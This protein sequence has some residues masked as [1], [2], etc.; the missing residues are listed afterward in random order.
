[1]YETQHLTEPIQSK[2]TKSINTFLQHPLFNKPRLPLPILQE[3]AFHQYSDSILWVPML[4]LMLSKVR[5]PRLKRALQENIS[6]ETGL[7]G[8]SHIELA[9]KMMRS[10]GLTNLDKFPISTYSNS[11][12]MWLSNDFD[13]FSEPEI[14]GWLLVAETLVPLMFKKMLQHFVLA[15]GCDTA[16]FSEHVAVDGDEHS[17]WMLEAATEIAELGGSVAVSQIMAG[18]DDAYEETVSIPNKLME[19]M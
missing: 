19:A 17:R 13:S 16:Y 8:S 11:A 12:Q 9:R 18:M 4:S 15:P 6:H 14:A 7:H 2:L 3:F 1:M 5:A 10:L